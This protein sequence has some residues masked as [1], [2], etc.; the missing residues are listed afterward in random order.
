MP[1]KPPRSAKPGR[2]AGR[3]PDSVRNA[4]LAAA[5]KYFTSR[6]FSAVSVRQIALNAGVNP[7]MIHYYFQDKQ[8]LYSAMLQDTIG[9]LLATLDANQHDNDARTISLREFLSRY[10]R[11]ISDNPWLPNLIVREVFYGNGK[12]RNIFIRKFAKRMGERLQ[13]LIRQEGG[14]GLLRQDLDPAMAAL[15]LISMSVF[16]FIARPVAENVLNLKIN[17]SFTDDLIKH[18]TRLFYEGAKS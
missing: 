11:L 4:L 7:A 2:P 10:I 8:G 17:K 5:R 18:T 13:D 12:F 16:P 15:S 1:T 14:K 3:K 6:D 9:P